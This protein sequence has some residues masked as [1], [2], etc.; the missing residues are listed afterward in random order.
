VAV[1]PQ[2]PS[3]EC[4]DVRDDLSE[5]ALGTLGGRDR[6]RVL[7]HVASCSWC[8]D[9]FASLASV[10]DALLCLGP[11]S[12]PPVGF[13]FRLAQR[14]HAATP[15][16]RTRQYLRAAILVAAALVLVVAGVAIGRTSTRAPLS[17][18]T[19]AAPVS[20]TLTSRGHVRGHLWLSAGRPTWLYMTISDAHR[21]GPAWCEVTLVNGRVLDVGTFSL[22]NGYGAWAAA[23]N[24]G[25][26]ALASARVTDAHGV[27]LASASL[28]A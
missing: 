9:E 12:E 5:C 28:S 16:R 19:S 18:A 25:G 1:N 8:R 20:A 10:A 6:A 4:R 22:S 26:S 7:D 14:L 15:R 3:A 24:L 27:V 11:T 23:L 17:T 21:S 2:G 13:E